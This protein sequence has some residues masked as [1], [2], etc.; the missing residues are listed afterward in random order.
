M[1]TARMR[2]RP[3]TMDDLDRMHALH[4]DPE[5]MRYLTGGAPI[6]R[7]TI[8]A[9]IREG[10]WGEGYWAAETIA[11]GEWL[12]WFALH[13]VT[14]RQPGD[15]ELGYRLRQAAWG[16]GY[17]TEGAR[18]LVAAGFADPAVDRVFAQ[19][20]AVNRGSRRVMEKTRLRFVR[21]V[22]LEWDDPL[23]G[24]E[25][26]EVEYALTRAEWEASR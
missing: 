16:K 22:H 1:T 4:N 11:D 14:G 23:P 5:V 24:T 26:G 18:S 3:I 25:E 7:E 8:G 15:R 10:S 12:G 9:E 2:L 17:A 21:V 6:A 19:T 20:M 13:P